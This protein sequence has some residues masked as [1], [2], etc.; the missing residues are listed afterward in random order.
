MTCM[1]FHISEVRSATYCPRQAYY[2]MRNDDTFEPDQEVQVLKSIARDY[3]R[4]LEAPDEFVKELVNGDGYSD[5]DSVEIDLQKIASNLEV[6][7]DEFD[8]WD[9][10]TRP[11]YVHLYLDNG[12]LHGT[13]E[14]VFKVKI[15]DM[16]DG[17]N[18]RLSFSLIKT[19]EPPE[20]GVWKTQRTEASAAYRL[21]K[22]QI[23]EVDGLG[24][25]NTE[26][27]NPTLSKEIFVEYPR[28]GKIRKK[29]IRT[30]DFR[31]LD[32]IIEKLKEASKG[33][34]PSRIDNRSKCEVCDYR[35]ECGV[36]TQ[37]LLT[38]LRSRVFSDD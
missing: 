34:P 14:K 26:A 24:F 8:F 17:S 22:D 2:R 10:I 32:R 25:P 6:T 36:K 18:E 31:R 27:E 19:G 13:L 3:S 23:R 38:R 33:Y 1:K 30:D 35:E 20:N 29:R 37:S 12:Q 28:V 9:S 4:F 15:E 16:D 7:R 11:L 21:F 5:S